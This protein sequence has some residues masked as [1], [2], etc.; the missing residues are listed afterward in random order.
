MARAI[1]IVKHY[2]FKSLDRFVALYD[3]IVCYRF[4]DLALPTAI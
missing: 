1:I 2:S 4:V 3:C